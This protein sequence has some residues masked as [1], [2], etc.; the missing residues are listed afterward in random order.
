VITA[1][2]RPARG[3][4]APLLFVQ[5]ETDFHRNV[6]L[7]ERLVDRIESPF[8]AEEFLARVDALARVRRVVLRDHT[9]SPPGIRGDETTG[10]IADGW[11]RHVS[12]RVASL[13]GS[14]LPRYAKPA[15][16]YLEVATRLAEWADQ[17][18]GFEPGHAERVTHFSAMIA[19]ELGLP[20]S[21]AGHLLRAAM[22]H[23]IGKVALPVEILQQRGPLDRDQQRLVR[24][25]PERGAAIL[26]ALDPDE[27]V[28]QAILL[29]HERA[30]GLGYY[31]KKPSEIPLAARVLSVAEVFDAMTRTQVTRP[32]TFNEAIDFLRDQRGRQF[33]GECVDAFI[34]AM[35]P[36]PASVRIR[37]ETAAP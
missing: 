30:D 32:L 23:D 28:I 19:D 34:E 20:D 11:W 12:R 29:H 33:D 24:T 6:Q 26:R 1:P 17:R 8:S 27:E 10:E 36:R 14:R 22:L 21:E 3:F 2:G 5:S 15:G 7:S 25:H 4:P 31:S 37:T 18:D 35:R 13:L 9:E 16:P